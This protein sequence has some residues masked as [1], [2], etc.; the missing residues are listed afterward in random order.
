MPHADLSKDIRSI[1]IGRLHNISPSLSSNLPKAEIVEGMYREF[2]EYALRLA[3]FYMIV[4]KNRHDKL[5]KFDT[6]PSK[7]NPLL[8]QH[9]WY[10]LSMLLKG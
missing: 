10:H 2:P 9:F 1:D 5:K 3:R 6:F 8:V 4:N 7:K